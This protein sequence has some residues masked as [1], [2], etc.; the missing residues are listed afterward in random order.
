MYRIVP[1]WWRI[2]F[3]LMLMLLVAVIEWR[4][5]GQNATKWKEYGFV[6]LT[7]LLGMIFGVCNDLITSSISPEYFIFG[8]GL[9]PGDGLTLRAAM[10]GAK[11]GFTAGAFAGAICLYASTRRC[12]R[13][14]LPYG[15]LVRLLWRPF[16]LAVLAALV[17]LLFHRCAPFT[18]LAE[19]K[20][21][22]APQQI[23]RF[24]IVWC[25]HVGLYSGLLTAVVWIVVDIIRLRRRQ[26][27]TIHRQSED[28][29]P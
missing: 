24:M 10:L 12:S 29:N 18:F 6:V 2:A 19:L 27:A 20:G 28:L 1:F 4:R 22:L 3:L 7:G 16:V 25:I 15:S 26:G 11:A 13:P 23:H 5:K 17:A 21:I 8:K 9:S 14:S